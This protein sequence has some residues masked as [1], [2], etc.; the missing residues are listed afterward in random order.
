[1]AKLGLFVASLLAVVE[2]SI[3]GGV[4]AAEVMPTKA[5]STTT[6]AAAAPH[7]CTDP[8]DF[9]TT[10]CQLTWNGITVFGIVDMGFGWQSHGA[11]FDPKSAVSSSYLIQKQNRGSIW[12]PTANALSNSTIGIK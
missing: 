11:P 1:M 7:P 4:W 5:Q 6:D 9:V 3:A 8:S 12:T 2:A 10:N